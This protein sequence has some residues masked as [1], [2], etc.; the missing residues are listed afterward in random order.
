MWM[1]AAAGLLRVHVDVG[2]FQLEPWTV[3]SVQ[4]HGRAG[5]LVLKSMIFPK[6]PN[7]PF[8]GYKSQNGPF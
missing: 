1:R 6:D 8:Q 5:T 2:I 3:S 7:S 4:P